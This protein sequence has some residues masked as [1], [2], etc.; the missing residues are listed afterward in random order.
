MQ[1]WEEGGG[2]ERRAFECIVMLPWSDLVECS[3]ER[4]D[5]TGPHIQASTHTQ[6][7]QWS[8]V[9]AYNTSEK[10]L[11]YT[12][13]DWYFYLELQMCGCFSTNDAVPPNRFLGCTAI[14]LCAT[15]TR[16]QVLQHM[17]CAMANPI[18]W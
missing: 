16:Q 3:D 2:G 11:E 10:L 5:S 17:D 8:H 12:V 1:T 7:S 13:L 14:E 9:D 6:T 15:N 18:D 4:M